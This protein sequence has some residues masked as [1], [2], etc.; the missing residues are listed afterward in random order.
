[1]VIRLSL[2]TGEEASMSVAL[3]LIEWFDQDGR[4]LVYRFPPEGAT[5]IT[6][7]A[8]LVVRESQAAVFFRDGKGLDVFGAGR[9][10]LSTLNLPILTK[11]LSL[12]WGFKSPFRAEV[13][14]V[15]LKAFP[16][17][18]WGTK[19]PVAFKDKEFGLIRLRAFGIFGL[20]VTQ[21]LLFVNTLVGTQGAYSSQQVEDY[22]RDVIVS[23]LNDFLGEHVESIVQLP[24]LYD[25][26]GVAVKTRL[27]DDFRRYGLELIDCFVNAITPPPEVQKMIDE[28]SGMGAVGDLDRFLK[29]KAA[30]A[31]GDAAAGVGGGG[32]AGD[33]AAAGM[34]LGVGTGFGF[35]L[36]GMLYRAMNPED[37]DPQRIRERGSVTCPDCQGEVPLSAR[38]CPSCGNQMVVMS[39]CPQCGKN[40]TVQAKFCP[41]CGHNLHAALTCRHCRAPLPPRTKFCTSCGEAVEPPG[42]EPTA[43]PAS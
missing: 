34:G 5:D 29:F 15:N 19:E 28:R 33:T 14:F 20:R 43:P 32:G 8:Q 4:Q 9:H 16:D 41:A 2:A 26:I 1:L 36:P 21:P 25:E 3:E 13:C 23:R 38:F 10:T 42:G 40:V 24:Q 17:L 12:P 35:M 6:M 27:R 31:L 11:V 18:K 37:S 7:G 22:L 30:K 39:K